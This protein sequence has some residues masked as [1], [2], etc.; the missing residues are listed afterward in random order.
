MAEHHF[1]TIKKETRHAFGKNIYLIGTKNGVQYWLE[2]PTW[3][4]DWYWGFGYVKTYT[5]N[6]NPEIAR[7]SN[8]SQHFD[9]MFFDVY[10][11]MNRTASDV[12]LEFFDE[13]PFTEKEVFQLLDLMQSFYTCRR[14]ADMTHLGH[15][16]YIATDANILL[17]DNDMYDKI[18]RIMIPAIFKELKNILI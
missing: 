8:S 11:N 15:S 6:K 5:N 2:E 3:D 10:K 7:D 9:I 14:M 17:R 18:N 4:C 12:F 16:G 13:T 1:A